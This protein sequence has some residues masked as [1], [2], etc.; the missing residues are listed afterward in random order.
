MGQR[1][2]D[3]ETIP[4]CPHHHQHGGYGVAFHAGPKK[5]QELHGTE[6]ELLEQ[7]N[8]ILENYL[9]IE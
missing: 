5:W 4:L 2:T 9:R 6:L 3:D 8:D 1:A 7:T